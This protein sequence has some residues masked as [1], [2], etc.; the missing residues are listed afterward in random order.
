MLVRL[1]DG[2]TKEVLGQTLRYGA[3]RNAREIFLIGK[4]IDCYSIWHIPTQTLVLSYY[5]FQA[6]AKAVAKEAIARAHDILLSPEAP[7]IQAEF[8][9]LL[10]EYMRHYQLNPDKEVPSFQGWLDVRINEPGGDNPASDNRSLPLPSKAKHPQEL[11]E[12]H[13]TLAWFPDAGGVIRASELSI[14]LRNRD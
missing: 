3:G 4:A 10:L 5:Y 7:H 14:V 12:G 11:P 1:K 6:Q 8:P 2:G 9:P 13:Q